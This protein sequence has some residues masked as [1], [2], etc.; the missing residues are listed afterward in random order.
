VR[1]ARRIIQEFRVH[2]VYLASEG[3][4]PPSEVAAIEAHLA[5]CEGCRHYLDQMC[6]TLAAL[7]SV[8]VET[9]SD[10][11]INALL[12]AFPGRPS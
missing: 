11:A 10:D 12:A 9:L 4:L 2:I 6:A 7:G 8:P 3:A 5:T 1:A